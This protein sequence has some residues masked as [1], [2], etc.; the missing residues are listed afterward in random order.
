MMMSNKKLVMNKMRNL[1]PKLHQKMKSKTKKQLIKKTMSK[2]MMKP[3]KMKKT[4][5]R[6]NLY[7]NLIL[8][9]RMKST[10]KPMTLTLL[11]ILNS[12]LIHPPQSILTKM[13]NL[14]SLNNL[15]LMIN[16]LLN[17]KSKKK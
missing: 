13:L 14:M 11:L 15:F 3:L 2:L 9:M 17:L 4:K 8:M 12:T 6:K 5:K 16:L 10:L 1:T 7:L